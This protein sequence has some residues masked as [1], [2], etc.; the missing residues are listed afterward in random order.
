MT[1]GHDIAMHLRSAYL[2]LHR[3]A[4]NHFAS[5]G[6]TADQYVLL[7]LLAA[8]DGVKQQN[9]VH[10]SSSDPNTVR[11]ILLLLEERGL[12]TRHQHKEDRRARAV[13][14]TAKGRRLQRELMQHARQLHDMISAAVPE[15][16]FDSV[17]QCLERI[18]EA[19]TRPSRT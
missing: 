6:V 18:S 5:S 15:E 7:T 8:K 11:A 12:I 17:M 3:R 13:R 9:L 19:M 16:E 4:Q 14:L 2:T 1:R 10:R